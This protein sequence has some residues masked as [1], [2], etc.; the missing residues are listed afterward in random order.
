MDPFGVIHLEGCGDGEASVRF[1]SG[2]VVASW[3][4]EV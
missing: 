3:I 4:K 1:S 2:I